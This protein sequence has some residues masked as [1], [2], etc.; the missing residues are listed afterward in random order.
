VFHDEPASGEP[1]EAYFHRFL[2]VSP[3][4]ISAVAATFL[5]MV[6]VSAIDEGR[7]PLSG[8]KTVLD[9]SGARL[10]PGPLPPVSSLV[11]LL[12]KCKPGL[13]W[14]LFLGRLAGFMRSS[15]R[16]GSVDAR[17]TAV[18]TRWTALIREAL[19]AVD[20]YNISP[21]AAL[22]KLLASMKEVV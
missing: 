18:Y 5:G 8:L 2:P 15:L 4:T 6:L 17:E 22:E 13:V 19:D 9:A 1:L 10:P 21:A 12:N 14:H 7:R 11:G 20:V 16:T 3:E